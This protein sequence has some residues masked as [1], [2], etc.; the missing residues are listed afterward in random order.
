M[1]HGL[2]H[3]A[4]LRIPALVEAQALADNGPVRIEPGHD[5]FLVEGR[6]FHGRVFGKMAMTS[7]FFCACFFPK[8]SL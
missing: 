4:V 8:A 5:H 6:V 3:E 2:E 1:L 7:R